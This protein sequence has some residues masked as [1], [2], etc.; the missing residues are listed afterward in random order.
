M[1]QLEKDFDEMLSGTPIAWNAGE[2][3]GRPL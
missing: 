2:S 3:S 1:E